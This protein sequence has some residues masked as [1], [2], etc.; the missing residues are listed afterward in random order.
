MEEEGVAVDPDGHSLITAIGGH[1]STIWIHDDDGEHSLSSEGEAST[2]SLRA[3]DSLLFYLLRRESGDQGQELWSMTLATGETHPVFPGTSMRAYDI[4]PDGKYAVYTTVT[5]DGTT[6]LEIAPIDKSSPAV[7]IGMGGETSPYFGAHG[8]VLFLRAEGNSNYLEYM[9]PDGSGRSK[10][11]QYPVNEIQG[12]SPGRRW[13]MAETT[14]DGKNIA[15]VAIPVDGGPP[16]LLCASYCVPIWSSNGNYLF[17]PVEFPSRAS[18][19]RSLA[20][21]VGPEERL[22]EFPPSGI[23]PFAQPSV[24]PGSQSVPRAQLVP[25]KDPSHY[26]YVNVTTHRN[27]YRISLP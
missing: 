3:N 9:N 24:M 22:P 25:G 4:S 1:E 14:P 21:P 27:L 17:V 5:S 13:V 20:I 12:V 2:I 15:P 11:V 8:Q 6:Q 26:V 18:P 16:R 7:R 23:P 10:V 19:G